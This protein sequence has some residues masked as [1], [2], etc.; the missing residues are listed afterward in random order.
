M[1]LTVSDMSH[2][3]NLPADL[4]S[5]VDEGKLLNSLFAVA[6]L[7]FEFRGGEKS[8]RQGRGLI[9]PC[10]QKQRLM[11]FEKLLINIIMALELRTKYKNTRDKPLPGPADLCQIRQISVR[12]SRHLS[13]P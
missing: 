11:K 9:F 5:A 2:F 6:D 10:V 8:R 1:Y 4:A 13:G 7:G 3:H 12:S